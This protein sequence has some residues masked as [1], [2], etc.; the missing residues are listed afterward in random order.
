MVD[1]FSLKERTA[2]LA[3]LDEYLWNFLTEPDLGS[4]P[5]L[6]PNDPPGLVLTGSV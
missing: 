2:N 3:R 4:P 5:E 1:N 6:E